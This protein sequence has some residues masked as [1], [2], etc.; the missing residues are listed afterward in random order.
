[1]LDGISPLK[2]FLKI[3]NSSGMVKFPSS[4]ITW[5]EILD[6]EMS[7]YLRLDNV[8]NS[9]GSVPENLLY[10]ISKCCNSDN[11]P[12][13]G[14]TEPSNALPAKFRNLSISKFP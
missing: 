10:P 3:Y 13:S 1:M 4:G 6:D 11:N 14:G 8:V 12:S 7:K 9:T 2:R 5:P